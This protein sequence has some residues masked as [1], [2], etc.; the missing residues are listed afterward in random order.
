MDAPAIEFVDINVS[1][2]K[3][4]V[5]NRLS[6]TVPAGE[7]TVIMGPSGVG[8]TTLMKHLLGLLG[9][10]SGSVLI[11]GRSAWGMRR[12]EFAELCSTFGVLLGGASLYDTSIFASMSVLDNV[13][14]PLKLGGMDP[15]N[16]REEALRS[17]HEFD[18]TAVAHS[19]PPTL[20]AGTRRRVALAKAMVGQ[21]SLVV[22]DDPDTAMDVVHRAAIVRSIRSAQARGATILVVTHNIRLAKAIGQH[23]A[24]L[25]D[26]RIAA[27]GR[28]DE[29]LDGVDSADDFTHRFPINE[30]PAPEAWSGNNLARA[31]R[32]QSPA[33]W[34]WVL[35]AMVI[36]LVVE[37]LA[38]AGIIPTPNR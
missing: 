2:G 27:Q 1:R 6:L 31:L 17:L 8:K 29:L 36:M 23:L 15:K 30:A 12:T 9:P 13:E 34:T 10:D 16:S 33:A 5:L 37:A 21:P 14:Y 28:P 19:M 4:R 26:G 11:D 24:V 38:V 20:S 18:L 35:V 3:N 25:V 7:T 32:R 22:L